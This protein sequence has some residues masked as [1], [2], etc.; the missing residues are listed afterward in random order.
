MNRAFSSL[1]SQKVSGPDKIPVR[2][3]KEHA[4]DPTCFTAGRTVYHLLCRD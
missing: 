2:S 1:G 3:L 4:E